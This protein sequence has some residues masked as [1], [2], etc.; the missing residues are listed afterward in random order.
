MKTIPSSLYQVIK[1]PT[2]WGVFSIREE[3]RIS[4]ECYRIAQDYMPGIPKEIATHKFNVDLFYPLVRQVRR[5]F[6]SAINDAVCEEVEKLLENGSISES[7][8]PQ[9]VANLIDAIIGH[10]LLSF[11]DAYSGYNQILIEEEDQEKTTFITHQGMYC[12][13]VM[14]FGL[15]NAG[16]TYQRLVTRIFKDQLGKTMEVYIDDMLVKSR[17]KEDHIDHQKE[18]FGILRR[19]GM[20]LNPEKC[21]FGVTS[22]K[23]LGFLVYKLTGRIAALSRFISRLS[24]KCHKF[25]GVLKKDNGL[26]WTSECVQALKELKAYLSSPPLLAKAEPGECLLVYHAVSEVAV[27]AILVR[28]EKVTTFPLRCILHKP[29]LSGRLA[30]WAIELSEHDITYHPRTVIKS[31][32][33]Y[34][35]VADFSAKIMPEVEKEIAHASPPTQDQ[36]ILYTDSASNASG[37][38]LGLVL[39]VPTGKVIRQ[40]IRCPDM[41]NNKAEYEAVITELKLELKYRARRVILRCD[42]QLVVNQVTGTFQ[43]KGCKNTK[44]KFA[45]YCPSLMNANSTKSFGDKT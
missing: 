18:A 4:R 33:L 24:N 40:S 16:A 44:P 7:K 21:A 43:S 41:T 32:V 34:D 35:F 29:E 8:Y 26:L 1:F 45:N 38:G 31:Q 2:P 17:R 13:R 22:G 6:N 11:L 37:S 42:S 25:F 14:L 9:W 20:K 12:C 5:K 19:Y 27:S 36:W 39:E 23:I 10:E 15:K 3:Q 28:E 30:K